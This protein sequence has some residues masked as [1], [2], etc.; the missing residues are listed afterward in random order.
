MRDILAL[1]GDIP[2]G[3][4]REEA[5]A[6]GFRYAADLVRWLCKFDGLHSIGV[7]CYPE[8]HPETPDKAKDMDH[9]GPKGR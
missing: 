6:G 5:V 4:T 1:R 3:M 2:E 9:F 7:A 8:G